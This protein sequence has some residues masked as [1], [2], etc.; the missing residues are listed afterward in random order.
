MDSVPRQEEF[1]VNTQSYSGMDN[2]LSVISYD[3]GKNFF[4]TSIFQL[5]F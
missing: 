2:R 5:Q 1:Q 4:L 3:P